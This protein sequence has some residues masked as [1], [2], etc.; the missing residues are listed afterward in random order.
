MMNILHWIAIV[1]SS[2]LFYFAY[3]WVSNFMWYSKTYQTYQVLYASP[4]FYIALL[5]SVGL[6]MIVDF[7]YAAIKLN[8]RPTCH[9]FLRL[10]S[11]NRKITEDDFKKL[12]KLN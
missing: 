10:L 3:G 9:D 11:A 4:S 5:F 1:F 8:I 6:C 2:W 7:G 12:Q